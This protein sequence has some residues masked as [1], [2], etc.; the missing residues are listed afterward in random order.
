[1]R[2]TIW[3]YIQKHYPCLENLAK[4]IALGI[5][6]HTSHVG[7]PFSYFA[8][9]KC[10]IS[11]PAGASCPQPIN[12]LANGEP[13]GCWVTAWPTP[14]SPSPYT[15]VPCDFVSYGPLACHKGGPGF[16]PTPGNIPQY[17]GFNTGGMKGLSV[18]FGPWSDFCLWCWA[19]YPH[20]GE[21][22]DPVLILG[23]DNYAFAS[24]TIF[25]G[26]DNGEAQI[27]EVARIWGASDLST[28]NLFGTMANDAMGRPLTHIGGKPATSTELDALQ[29]FVASRKIFIYNIWPWSRCGSSSSGPA[30]I[31]GSFGSLPCLWTWLDSLIVC[32]NP[33]KVAALGDWSYATPS[34]RH[35]TPD[36]FL[37][38]YSK[39]LKPT[40]TV[41][42]FRHPS[43][44][45]KP[46]DWFSSWHYCPDISS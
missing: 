21:G 43:A 34:A 7:R 46:H 37:R 29:T 10:A 19:K 42:V 3:D 27:L 18:L 13:P 28:R 33:K 38:K 2:K 5:H 15:P 24:G 6:P 26:I 1:M 4:D 20:L 39:A 36:A 8:T 25:N 35:P 44:S 9:T 12:Y 22:V 31:H 17:C 11:M 45:R 40:I 41:D 16:T 14:A 30:G 32:L 23:K